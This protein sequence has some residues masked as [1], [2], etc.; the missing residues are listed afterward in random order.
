[1]TWLTGT[2]TG[3]NTLFKDICHEITGAP[4]V[5]SGP[6][7][8][9]T[10]NGTMDNVEEISHGPT[11]TFTVTCSQVVGSD[12][13]VPLS[14]QTVNS[15]G[16]TLQYGALMF[17]NNGTQY[18]QYGDDISTGITYSRY[19]HKYGTQAFFIM[20]LVSEGCSA[21]SID[22]GAS[23]FYLHVQTA[24]TSTAAFGETMIEFLDAAQSVI[25]TTSLGATRD[26]NLGW[27]DRY[28]KKVVPAGCRYIKI[29]RI[30]N[31]NGSVGYAGN[32]VSKSFCQITEATGKFSVSGSVSGA[33][34]DAYVGVP[35]NKGPIYFEINEG[36][37]PF[38]LSDYF[39]V[40]VTQRQTYTD[41][42]YW[43]SENWDGMTDLTNNVIAHGPA[44]ALRG[45]GTG[46][47]DNIYG[48]IKLA[49]YMAA[50]DDTNSPRLV[51]DACPTSFKER[52]HMGYLSRYFK[53]DNVAYK[54]HSH[55]TYSHNYGPHIPVDASNQMTWWIS[56]TGRR[57]ILVIKCGTVYECG[58]VGWGLPYMLPA[59]YP[60]P[61]IVGGSHAGYASGTHITSQD[62]DHRFFIDPVS[63]ADGYEYSQL[64]VR[65]PA[66]NWVGIANYERSAY[67]VA[68]KDGYLFRNVWPHYDSGMVGLINN[69]DGTYPILPVVI[70]GSGL[71]TIQFDG[72]F[73]TSGEGGLVAEDIIQQ[74]G[75]DYF[76]V[77]D[78]FRN[79]RRSYMLVKKV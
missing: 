29:H 65:N 1:M 36:A 55:F 48:S 74:G 30:M 53:T 49:N 6:T 21:A 70:F 27:I 14:F 60:H 24:S 76:V 31:E 15:T 43:E 11:E 2:S 3:P 35:Y 33:L 16:W 22:A 71:A 47:A 17:G 10:G 79:T 7:L 39:T 32:L 28:V 73:T 68:Y 13:I 26:Y 52:G 50:E 46:G 61:Y 18:W 4:Q 42:T 64:F 51:F 57:I 41:D 66:N 72:V 78:T 56:I 62:I 58:Y 75:D 9:G 63:Q 54:L 25:K 67:N 5:T 77:P 8:T 12:T 59:D 38:A 34:P 69:M 40:G 37:T 23:V 20:D 44:I 45:R 19:D